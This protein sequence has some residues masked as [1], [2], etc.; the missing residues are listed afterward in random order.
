MIA[1][2]SVLGVIAPVCSR[3]PIFLDLRGMRKIVNWSIMRRIRTVGAYRNCRNCGIQR[4]FADMGRG[5]V[6]D[7]AFLTSSGGGGG[8]VF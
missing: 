7:F 6:C 4:W 5:K 2:R 1:G 3:C 8:G